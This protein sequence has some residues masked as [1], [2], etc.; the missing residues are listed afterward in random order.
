MK[1]SWIQVNIINFET[2]LTYN[3]KYEICSFI[4]FDCLYKMIRCKISKIV[5]NVLKRGMQLRKNT[6]YYQVCRFT[7]VSVKKKYIYTFVI[8][9]LFC[10]IYKT[11]T[12]NINFHQ[13]FIQWLLLYKNIVLFKIYIMKNKNG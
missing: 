5:Q 8:T 11:N 6:S 10:F 1:Q 12:K 4:H 7:K 2:F 9:S 3:I 13:T